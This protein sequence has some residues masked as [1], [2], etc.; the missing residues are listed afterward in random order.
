MHVYPSIYQYLEIHFCNLPS[1]QTSFAQK[2]KVAVLKANST[3]QSRW[4]NLNIFRVQSPTK[5]S[6]R[7]YVQETWGPM[8]PLLNLTFNFKIGPKLEVGFSQTR[9]V[10]LNLKPMRFDIKVMPLSTTSFFRTLDLD[11][12]CKFLG[13]KVLLLTT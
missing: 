1:P 8:H 10:I 7:V 13:S 3:F 9:T 5:V 12:K 11:P 6:I 4:K 2:T